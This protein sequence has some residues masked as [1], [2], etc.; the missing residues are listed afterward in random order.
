MLLGGGEN[1]YR[2]CRR[3]LQRLEEGVEGLGA[4]HVDLIDDKHAVAAHLRRD[5]HLVYKSLYV[6]YAIVGGGIQFVN[7]IGASLRE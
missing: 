5:A 1:E 6:L 3:F 4:E 7:A 2:M